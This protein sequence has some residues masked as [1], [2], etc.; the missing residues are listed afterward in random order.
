MLLYPSLLLQILLP[1][2]PPLT[3]YPN[4]L[5]RIRADLLDGNS[6]ASPHYDRRNS[7]QRLSHVG[8]DTAG[9]CAAHTLGSGHILSHHV[10]IHQDLGS[11]ADQ[12]GPPDRL[13]DFAVPDHILETGMVGMLNVRYFCS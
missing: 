1:V 10:D 4:P 13:T 6:S 5:S 2:L 12:A 7:D 9:G 11:L 3:Q 8:G